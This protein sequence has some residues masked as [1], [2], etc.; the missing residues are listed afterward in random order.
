MYPVLMIVSETVHGLVK[1]A[2]ALHALLLAESCAGL[3]AT[4]TIA[5]QELQAALLGLLITGIVSLSSH[6]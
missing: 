4:N 6:L 5:S 3:H 2:V 1:M